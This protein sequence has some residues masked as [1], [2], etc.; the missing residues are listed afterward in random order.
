MLAV[1]I[2]SIALEY[3]AANASRNGVGNLIRFERHD[4]ARS[5]PSGTFDLVTVSFLH[6]PIDWPRAKVL[7]RA[8]EAVSRGGHLLIVE[9]ASRAP[10]SWAAPNT[11]Y[12]TAD[13]TLASLSLRGNDWS[14]L[15]VAA[16]ER[17]A[18]GPDGQTAMV[19]DNVIFL[20]RI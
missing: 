18:T 1:D 2:S 7:S 6:S 9:H 16:I 11:Q 13:E 3:A 10:W 20:R 5:F 19:R 14:Y 15:H 8:A 12:P 17:R 4:L